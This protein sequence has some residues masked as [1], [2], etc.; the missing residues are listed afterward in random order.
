LPTVYITGH[1]EADDEFV[2]PPVDI[3]PAP[4]PREVVTIPLPQISGL[5]PVEFASVTRT[6]PV[7]GK[8]PVKLCIAQAKDALATCQKEAK[9]TCDV[10][11]GAANVG[12]AVCP[13]VPKTVPKILCSV[14]VA[15]AKL[16]TAVAN[17][18]CES[19][20]DDSVN[21]CH[22]APRPGAPRKMVP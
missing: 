8:N 4:A 21:A 6:P 17:Y 22:T 9:K 1:Y 13:F 10:V 11:D 19:A 3:A 12:A 18:R 20:Y 16:C 15:A 14:A 7:K 2:L 5:G